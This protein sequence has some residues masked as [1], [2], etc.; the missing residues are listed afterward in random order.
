MP[1]VLSSKPVGASGDGV[2]AETNANV[3]TAAAMKS[4][5]VRPPRADW[6]RVLPCQYHLWDTA[7]RT[8]KKEAAQVTKALVC[9]EVAR[10]SGTFILGLYSLAIIRAQFKTIKI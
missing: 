3:R 4:F 7:Q 6:G 8:K 10:Q 9:G 2:V 5:M 1:L